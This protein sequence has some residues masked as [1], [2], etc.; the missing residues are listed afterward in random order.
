MARRGRRTAVRTNGYDS[1]YEASVAADLEQRGVSP[2]EQQPV[3]YVSKRIYF[4]DFVLPNGIIVEA[5]GYFP[6]EDRRKMLDVRESNPELDIRMLLQNAES[7]LSKRSRTTYAKWCEQN[8]FKWAE[9]TV[10]DTWL[11]ESPRTVATL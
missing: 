8:G 10:P 7:K 2:D 5:K 6:R 1:K 4:A 3:E 9:G 11:A